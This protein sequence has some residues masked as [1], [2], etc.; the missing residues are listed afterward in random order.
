MDLP[1]VS[2]RTLPAG[3]HVVIPATARGGF[4]VSVKGDF[5]KDFVLHT[6]KT[7]PGPGSQLSFAAGPDAEASFKWVAGA[8][9]VIVP[10][11]PKY[12]NILRI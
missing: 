9:A 12:V 10:K 4:I 6:V 8:L 1:P 11:D 7:S 3:E 2:N 5:V